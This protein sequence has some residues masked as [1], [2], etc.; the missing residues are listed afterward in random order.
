MPESYL[1]ELVNKCHSIAIFIA[2]YAPEEEFE[3]VKEEYVPPPEAKDDWEQ[4][5]KK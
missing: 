5:R 1:K 2:P 3:V 4:A